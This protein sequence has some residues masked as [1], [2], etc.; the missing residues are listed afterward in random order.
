MRSAVTLPEPRLIWHQG[1]VTDLCCFVMSLKNTNDVCNVII[2]RVVTWFKTHEITSHHINY[3]IAYPKPRN[4][5]V[6]GYCC[7][8]MSLKPSKNQKE[9]S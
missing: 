7:N 4:K 6:L 1:Y 5:R 8:F 3:S 9:G 2:R